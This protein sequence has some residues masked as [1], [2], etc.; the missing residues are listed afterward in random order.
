MKNKR[1][2][3]PI[4]TVLAVGFLIAALSYLFHPEIGRLSVTINGEPI[5]DPFFRFAAVPTFFIV[6]GLALALTLLLFMGVGG[7]I[8][9]AAIFLAMA[10]CLLVVPYLW[11]F[12]AVIFLMV[13]LMSMT[14]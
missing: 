8:F 5:S 4:V 1:D 11:P 2:P 13:A 3:R 14:R 12:L 7:V 6:S 9:F 10:A